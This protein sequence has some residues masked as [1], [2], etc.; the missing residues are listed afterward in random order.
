MG[1]DWMKRARKNL[2]EMSVEKKDFQKARKEWVYIG[3]EDNEDCDAKCELCNHE[4]IRYEYT[5]K[6]KLNNN[7]MVVGSDCIGKFTDDFKTEFYDIHGNLVNKKRLTEDKNNYWK[8]ILYKSLDDYL[9]KY[10]NKFHQGITD[11][12]IKKDGKLT[13]KQLKYLPKLYSSLDEIG[14]EA[15]N[16][17]IKVRLKTN[18]QQEQLNNL[19]STEL[20]FVAQFMSKVQKDKYNIK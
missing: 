16:R 11:Q 4:E 18:E 7:T 3:L 15:F 2:L 12:S 14:Q 5:I 19:T 20:K 10:P 17:I 6:N 13:P 9:S 8:N 1:N